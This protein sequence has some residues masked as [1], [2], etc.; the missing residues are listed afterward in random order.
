MNQREGSIFCVWAGGG[1]RQCCKP[2]EGPITS[3]PPPS[4]TAT[5]SART[6]S[7]LL[8]KEFL[9]HSFTHAAA[10]RLDVRRQETARLSADD[11][12]ADSFTPQPQEM[13]AERMLSAC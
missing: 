1:T 12:K 4:Q 10:V 11:T 5:P 9:P 6:D 8:F 3:T 7:L 13:M 2:R